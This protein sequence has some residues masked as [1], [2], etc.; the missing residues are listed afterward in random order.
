MWIPY[1][2]R[3]AWEISLKMLKLAG[4]N[5]KYIHSITKRGYRSPFIHFDHIYSPPC[6]TDIHRW[7]ARDLTLLLA[8]S[9][10][11][12]KHPSSSQI[13]VDNVEQKFRVDLRPCHIAINTATRTEPTAV[14]C[15][16]S[17]VAPQTVFRKKSWTEL[18]HF[19]RLALSQT[20]SHKR[21][22]RARSPWRIVRPCR[23]PLGTWHWRCRWS[24]MD[25]DPSGTRQ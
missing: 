18:F 9:Y 23:S 15:R 10:R 25:Q 2:T 1:P 5:S 14:N 4:F 8:P 17:P 11:D 21:N 19:L 20:P 6:H 22:F 13:F 12:L 16:A 7:K 24:E 3:M